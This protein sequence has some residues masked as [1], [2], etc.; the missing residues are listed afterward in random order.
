MAD[1]GSY[2]VAAYV[3]VGVM[4]AGYAGSIWWRRRTLA[5]RAARLGTPP[6][7][8]GDTSRPA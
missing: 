5:A 8:S 2:F 6:A 4:Y 3:I 7:L 1:T